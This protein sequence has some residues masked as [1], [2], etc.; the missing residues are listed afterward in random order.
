[1]AKKRKKPSGFT[2]VETL[3][4]VFLVT[5]VFL[6]VFLSYQLAVK[7]TAQNKNK[8]TALAVATG[9]LEKIRNFSYEDVGTNESGC[10]PCGTI[11]KIQIKNINGIDYSVLTEIDYV[12]DETDG[13]ASPED[14]CP[15]DYKKVKVSV[16]WSGVSNGQVFLVSDISPKNLAEE[17][18]QTGGVILVS[19]FD[20]SGITIPSPFIEIRNPDDDTVVASAMPYEGKYFFPLMEEYYKIVVSKDGHTTERTY[21]IE[22]IANP[23]NPNLLVLEGEFIEKSF[24]ID[25]VSSFSVNTLSSWG[26][27]Y[28]SDSFPGMAKISD[29]YAVS[30]AEGKVFLEMNGGVYEAAGYIVSVPIE[31]S[32]L[33]GWGEFSSQYQEFESTQI[34]YQVLYYDGNDWI[35]IPDSDLPG[36]FSGFSEPSVDLSLLDKSV[37]SKIKIKGILA[38]EDPLVTPEIDSWSVSWKNGQPVPVGGVPFHLNGEKVIGTDSEEK[39]VYKHSEDYVTSSGGHVS[40]N[41]LDWDNYSFS[42]DP[43]SYLDMAGIEPPQPVLLNPDSNVEVNLYL[44]AQN[45]FLLSVRDELTDEPIFSADCRLYNDSGY[46]KMLETDES[47]EVYF[48]PLQSG[49]YN[50]Q[51][52][53]NGYS[54]Y[55]G[56]VSIAGDK[57]KA[58]SLT[59]EE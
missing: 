51:V 54:S 7:L 13:V 19:V 30:V 43:N 47:G 36:N 34:S 14:S 18:S 8:V 52:Q 58:V 29:Y 6:S 12:I 53:I 24:S 50:I 33:I 26:M 59:R 15:N 56:S 2:L 3:V 27:E 46:D 48:I 28:F 57:T 1:M 23:E 32:D 35:L 42:V 11:E 37:Y 9:E 31:P 45:S 5:V 25:K 21:S 10:Y 17:C 4:G 44:E 40:I 49:Y 55:S 16:S 20:A 39:T 22:E 41:N 38:T